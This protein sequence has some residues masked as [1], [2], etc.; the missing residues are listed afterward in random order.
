MRHDD[1]SQTRFADRV[2]RAL[3]MLLAVVGLVVL[4]PVMLIIATAIVVESGA[5]V[6]FSQVRLGRNGTHF[7]MYKFR[8]FRP[9]CS[10]SGLPL[11]LCNDD[12][13][14][15]VGRL[16]AITKLDELPQLYNILRGDMAFV[17]PRPESLALA[18]CF[19]EQHRAVL[20]YKPGIFGP[21]QIAFRSEAKLYP[22]NGDLVSFYREVLFPLKASLDL[23]Y[24]QRRTVFKDLAWIVRGVLAVIGLYP[25]QTQ[26]PTA[27]FLRTSLS[28]A[29]TV[30]ARHQAIRSTR[31]RARAA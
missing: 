9:D 10:A 3:D 5:P 31:R 23:E 25:T 17:G 1:R 19:D 20:N 8:K 13:T 26:Q 2:G 29:V 12:R 21:S 14:S 28:A 22:V 7:R 18:G 16:L 27:T 30:R 15:N 6:L 11:T 24:Y 4:S